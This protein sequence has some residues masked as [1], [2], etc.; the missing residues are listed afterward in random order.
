[1]NSNNDFYNDVSLQHE[2]SLPQSVVPQTY[3]IS[4]VFETAVAQVE[5]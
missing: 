4:D 2:F 3:L 1:M 5:G